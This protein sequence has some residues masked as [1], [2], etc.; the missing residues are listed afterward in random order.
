MT[1]ENLYAAIIASDPELAAWVTK[2][3]PSGTVVGTTDAQTLTNKTLTAPAITA[4]TGLI[5][6]DVGLSNVDNTSDA[7]KNAASVTLTNKTINASNNTVSNLTTTMFAASV[8]D[9]DGTLAANSATRLPTQAAVKAY[10]DQIIASADAMVFKGV[11]DCS[12]NP[13]YPAADRGWTYKVSVAGKIG[14]ASGVDVEVGDTLMC[15]TDGSA[16]GNQATVGA[17]WNIVQ[18]NLVGAV[19]GPAS[20]TS[21]NIATFNGTGGKVIQDGGKSLPSGAIVGTTDT[22]TLSG[23]T[24]NGASNTITV[25]LANDVTGNLPVANL[26]SGTSASNTTYWRGDGVWAVPAGSGSGVTSL[27]NQTGTLVAYFPPQGRLTLTT[28]TPVMTSTASGQ[29]TVYYTPACGDMLPIYDGSNLIPTVFAE[30]T[31]LTTD[32]T[33]SPA[34]VAANSNYDIFVWND[35]GTLRATRGPAWSS[36]TARG[37][38]AGTTELVRIKGLY[39]NANAITNGPAAQRGTYVGTIRS[40]GT[41]TIDWIL[42]ASGAGGTAAVL[43]VWNAYNRQTIATTVTDSNATWAYTSATVRQVDGSTGNQV[44]FVSGLAADGISAS[45]FNRASVAAV[46][47]AFYQIG[48]AMDSITA[49][50]KVNAYQNN[51][52][53]AVSAGASVTNNYGPQLGF[54]YIAALERSDGTNSVTFVG[55]TGIGLCVQVMA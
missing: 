24:I 50:D 1:V 54:H 10:A 52:A 40:N 28:A 41:S 55:G 12:A 22:Q 29:T 31:Q 5:K 2:T 27:N 8:V 44:S 42:G 6:D 47:G 36:S 23:K 13:N 4:P 48:I 17:N 14:G 21:G 45:Y 39:F 33:K 25:R 43:G 18:A 38:G 16:S 11:I 3:A 9:N 51:A 32:A 7:T 49:F 30:L 15:T 20:S 46:N 37:T 53:S 19:T 26:N 35:S 34:A